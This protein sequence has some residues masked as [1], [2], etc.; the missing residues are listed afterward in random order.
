MFVSMVTQDKGVSLAEKDIVEV[1][2]TEKDDEWLV[3]A[4]AD[5]EK[6]GACSR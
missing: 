3:R 1:L 6:V 5:K 4:Q 2:D